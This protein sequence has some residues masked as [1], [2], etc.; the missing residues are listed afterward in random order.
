MISQKES[1]QQWR[2]KNKEHIRDYN[3]Q[4]RQTHLEYIREYMREYFKKNGH[5]KY[6]PEYFKQWRELNG[7]YHKL[8]YQENRDAIIEYHRQYRKTEAGKANRQRSYNKR[9]DSERVIISTLTAEEWLNILNEY[10]FRCAYCK[11]QFN[12]FNRATRDHIIPISK[13]GHNV[14]ENVAPACKSCN[15]SKKDKIG[16]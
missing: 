8:Y 6:P 4:Y 15:S 9:R 13:G 11:K 10:Q 2:E 16:G 1:K 5:K 3:K 12:L 7:D 14:K